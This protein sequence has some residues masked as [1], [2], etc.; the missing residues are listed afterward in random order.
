MG[1]FDFLGFHFSRKGLT[2]AKATIYKF[3]ERAARLYEQEREEPDRSS[4]LGSYVTR[5]L[6]W[7][8]AGLDRRMSDGGIRW[9]DNPA[10]ELRGLPPPPRQKCQP[11]EAGAE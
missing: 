8:R 6:R 3:V 7:A 2:V 1:G 11:E 9:A 5:W 10:P 4:G